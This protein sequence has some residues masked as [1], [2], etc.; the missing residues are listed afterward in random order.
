MKYTEKL[1]HPKWQKKR[2]EILNRDNFTCQNCGST[3]T[4]LHVHHRV[5]SNGEP[6]EIDNKRLVALC[7]DCHES[8]K[9]KLI[10]Y[11]PLLLEQLKIKFFADDLRELAYG[12]EKLEL[13][14]ESRVV[15]SMIAYLL[16][17]PKELDLLKKRYFNFLKQKKRG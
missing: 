3:E 1:K 12:F 9:N 8:E 5:Y 7:E 13:N 4:T 10:Q 15:A 11:E 16:E 2:L 14:H 6:W 17:T